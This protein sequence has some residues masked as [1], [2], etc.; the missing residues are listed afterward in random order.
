[1]ALMLLEEGEGECDPE[2]PRIPSALE[3]ALRYRRYVVVDHLLKKGHVTVPVW[4]KQEVQWSPAVAW[5]C[6]RGSFAMAQYLVEKGLD[7]LSPTVSPLRTT[8]LEF[9]AGFTGPESLRLVPLLI[10]RGADVNEVTAQGLSLLTYA[11]RANNRKILGKLLVSGAVLDSPYSEDGS[12]KH[13][14]ADQAAS[15]LWQALR[16]RNERLAE[17]VL[18]AGYRAQHEPWFAERQFPGVTRQKV[19]DTLVKIT[20]QP[21]SLIS[22]CRRRLRERLGSALPAF[23]DKAGLPQA[24]A[25]FVLMKDLVKTYLGE[26]NGSA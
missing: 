18:V 17:M 9:C 16:T 13:D 4:V 23:L 25:D 21:L 8:P 2:N 11:V 14:G 15:F 24:V 5:C 19:V 22:A 7:C 1:M 6:Y 10:E 12:V 3:S 20:Q 26:A